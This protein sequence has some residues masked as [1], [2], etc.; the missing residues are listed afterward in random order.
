VKASRAS[1]IASAAFITSG[2]HTPTKVTI[3][4]SVRGRNRNL[5]SASLKQKQHEPQNHGNDPAQPANLASTSGG[6]SLSP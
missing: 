2:V 6:L 5:L 3:G 1:W 4:I